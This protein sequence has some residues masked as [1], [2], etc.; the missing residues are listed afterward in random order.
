MPEFMCE[1]VQNIEGYQAFMT[2]D[3]INKGVKSYLCI[4]VRMRKNLQT[5][6]HHVEK[7]SQDEKTWPGSGK[8]QWNMCLHSHSVLVKVDSTQVRVANCHLDVTSSIEERHRSLAEIVRCHIKISDEKVILCGDLNTFGCTLRNIFAG[9][10]FGVKLS[11]L[12]KNEQDLLNDILRETGLSRAFSRRTITHYWSF[13]S[14]LDHILFRGFD[15]H[16]KEL[17]PA[18]HNSD[19]RGL[20]GILK[21]VP[22]EPSL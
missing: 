6:G 5:A 18:R 4:L 3:M 8:F 11:E 1:K 21:D 10:F 12:F 16:K 14:G 19:H 13:F 9:W 22:R 17:M 15:L 20:S 7:H 2:L